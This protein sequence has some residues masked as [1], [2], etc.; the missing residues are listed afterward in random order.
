[1]NA[2]IEYSRRSYFF[3]YITFK[4]KLIDHTV[5]GTINYSAIDPTSADY[6]NSFNSNSKIT[7]REGQKEVGKVI[8][9]KVNNSELLDYFVQFSN[10]QETLLSEYIPVLKKVL[11][12]KY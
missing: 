11:N 12:L 2:D 9:N 5:D 10:K 8:L 3:K 4:I 7:I 6:I 1:M